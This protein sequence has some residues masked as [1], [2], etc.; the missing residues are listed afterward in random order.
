MSAVPSAAGGYLALLSTRYRALLQYRAAAAAGAFTQFFFGFVI[1]MV[2]EAFYRSSATTPP[3]AWPAVATYVWLGQAFFALLPWNHD[4]EIEAQ[5][6]RGDVAVELL[7]PVDLYALWLVRIVALRT[8]RASLRALPIA[9]GAG[10]VMPAAGL[11]EWALGP[12]AS[13]ASAAVWVLA[14]V[15]AVALGG[16]LTTLVHVSLLWT[17]SGEGMSRVMPAVV[18][19]FSGMV[20]PLPLFPAWSQPILRALPFRGLVDVPNR[21]Y[22]GDIPVAQAWTE[23]ALV[24]AWTAALVWA[25]RAL[26]RRGLRRLVVQGG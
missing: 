10:L 17:L 25:G 15:L 7:R 5:I 23:L 16:A 21:I 22:A 8:A 12:P 26:L 24:V 18:T 14:V 11:G 2:L 1:L 3:L 20:V 6:R 4:L 13:A 9:V 19:L